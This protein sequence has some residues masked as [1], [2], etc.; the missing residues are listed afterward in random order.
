LKELSDFYIITILAREPARIITFVPHTT[1][2][3]QMLDVMLFN[4]LQKHATSLDMLDEEPRTAAFILKIYCDFK[5]MMVEINIWRAC[6]VIEF[7][8]D[9]D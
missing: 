4:A 3:F 2:V 6:A 9:I 5:Q 8:H 1:H 7:T